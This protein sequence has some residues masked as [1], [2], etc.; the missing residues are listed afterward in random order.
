MQEKLKRFLQD[1]TNSKHHTGFRKFFK[2]N[3]E[4]VMRPLNVEMLMGHDSGISES[5][6]RPTEKEVLEDYLKAV[7]FLTINTDYHKATTLQKQVVELTE[8]SEEEN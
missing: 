3:A 8:K 1:A 2:S 4:R 7:D 5:Y 6:W